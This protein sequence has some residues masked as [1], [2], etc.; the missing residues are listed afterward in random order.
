MDMVLDVLRYEMDSR[1]P[2]QDTMNFEVS[3]R[4]N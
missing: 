4:D 3:M 1:L 2:W